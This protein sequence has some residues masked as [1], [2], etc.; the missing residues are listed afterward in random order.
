MQKTKAFANGIAI[1]FRQRNIPHYL[2]KMMKFGVLSTCLLLVDPTLSIASS[3]HPQD[4]RDTKIKFGVQGIS[5][6]NAL[7]KLQTESGYNIFYLS[8]KV[9]PY[10]DVTV[11]TSTRSIQGTLE[12]ILQGTPFTF[13]QEGKTIIISERA[14]AA[15]LEQSNKSIKK[16]IRGKVTDEQG[17]GLPGVTILQKGTQQGSITDEN[18]GYIIDVADDT[19]V[20]VFSFV[21]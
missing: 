2:S 7:H 15:P 21:G 16:T 3:H 6:K 1:A 12:E 5:L 19:S 4:I 14:E 18:G 9:A 17:E 20:L 13:R 11:N 10:K 8:T